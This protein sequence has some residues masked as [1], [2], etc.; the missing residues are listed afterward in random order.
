MTDEKKEH[1]KPEAAPESPKDPASPAEPP[2]LPGAEEIEALK[3]KAKERD[4]FLDL[5]Q[6]ARAELINYRKRV[7]RDRVEWTDRAV[8]DF[9]LSILPVLDDLDRALKEAEGA[10][11][12]KTMIEGFRQVDRKF[13]VV[14][15]AVGMESFSPQGKPFDPAEHEAV[16]IEE[17]DAHPHHAVSDV[18]RKGWTLRGRVL[19]AAQVKVAQKP[20]PKPEKIEK[21]GKSDEKKPDPSESKDAGKKES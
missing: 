1:P 2:K 21:P 15:K 11:D 10:K 17:T 18:M 12:V 19:R 5:A 16:V 8:G 4:E 3:A 7:E 9:A 13:H 20:E 6:R 14:L